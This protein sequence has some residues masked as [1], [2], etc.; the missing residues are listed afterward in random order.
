MQWLFPILIIASFLFACIGGRMSELCTAAVSSCT[1]G[2]KL[3]LTLLGGMAFWSGMMRIAEES[4]LTERITKLLSRPVRFI[5]DRLTDKKAIELICM[6]ITANLFGLANAATPLG[7]KAMQRLS[8]L[9]QNAQTA[10]YH[11]ILLVVINTASLQLIPTTVGL[12]RSQYGSQSPFSILP[13]TL[14]TSVCA[15][16]TAVC[17]V[18]LC[19]SLEKRREKRR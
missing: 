6:N 19:R 11:M 12:L 5:F 10:S 4:G 1:D 17:C 15:L 2:V 18:K 13:A 14:L 3:C 16:I 9:N 7:L 8:E